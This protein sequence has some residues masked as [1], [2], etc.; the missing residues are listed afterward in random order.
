MRTVIL[1]TQK[2]QL[3]IQA[4]E[5]LQLQAMAM[6]GQIAA[7]AAV[8]LSVG[9]NNISVGAGVFKVVSSGAVSVT[10]SAGSVQILATANDKDG[11]FPDPHV[12]MTALGIDANALKTFVPSDRSL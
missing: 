2:T 5:P 3:S 10:A 6:P 4:S 12:A 7:P 11:S 8:S 9:T 1:T